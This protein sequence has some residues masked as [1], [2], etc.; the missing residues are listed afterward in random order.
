MPPIDIVDSSRFTQAFDHG[1][2]LTGLSAD[3]VSEGDL[4]I[5]G[6]WLLACVR[7]S[8]RDRDNCAGGDCENGSSE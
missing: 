5:A 2:A 7:L 4:E 6:D 8:L 3:R 1:R